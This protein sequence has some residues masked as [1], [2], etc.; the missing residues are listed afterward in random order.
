[1]FIAISLPVS[2]SG[3]SN[4]EQES[5]RCAHYTGFRD[6]RGGA[7]CRARPETALRQI[8]PRGLAAAAH[9]RGCTS[10]SR[11]I[12]AILS[13]RRMK[14]PQPGSRAAGGSNIHSAST[15]PTRFHYRGSDLI[16]TAGRAGGPTP[17]Q[18]HLPR[19]I[20]PDHDSTW[21]LTREVRKESESLGWPP[22]QVSA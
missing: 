8:A 11:R 5:S 6:W 4:G 19:R 21:W 2:L 1:V 18:A 10:T 15:S 9:D 16:R 12:T 3:S 14:T 20:A 7:N 22:L 13:T 17:G